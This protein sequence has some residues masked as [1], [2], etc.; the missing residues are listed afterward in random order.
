MKGEILSK[1]RMLPA[2][3]VLT[4]ALGACG[5]Y[6]HRAPNTPPSEPEATTTEE[7]AG[8]CGGSCT[9]YL[10]CKGNL[11]PAALPPCMDRCEQLGLSSQQLASYERADCA[12][13]IFQAES[14]TYG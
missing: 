2:L 14:A 3:A 9:H 7:V 10:E 13:A 4:I 12:T 1:I 5:R 6:A 8:T 11:N